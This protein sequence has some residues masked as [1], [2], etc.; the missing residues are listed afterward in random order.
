ME[1]SSRPAPKYPVARVRNNSEDAS[2]R[3]VTFPALALAT[4]WS[5]A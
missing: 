4:R 2:Q 1:A 5:E 3:A